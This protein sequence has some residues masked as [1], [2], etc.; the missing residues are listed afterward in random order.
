[1]KIILKCLAVIVI[2]TLCSFGSIHLYE[3]CPKRKEELAKTI[4]NEINNYVENKSNIILEKMAKDEGF[5]NTVKTLSSIGDENLREVIIS[6][7]N[8]NPQTLEDFIRDNASFIASEIIET[9]EF[10]AVAKNIDNEET[11]NVEE[12]NVST[13]NPNQKYIDNWEKLSNSDVAPYIGPK[14][15]KI[16]VVEFF[17]F[18]C[19]HCKA[20]APIVSAVAKNNPDVKFVFNPLYFM[21]DHSPY[22]AKV[23]MAAH[24]KGKFIEVYDGI[25]TLPN[26][27]EETIN[28]ILVDEGLDIEE[29]KKMI[30]EKDIRRGSQD[31]D[32]LS[33]VLGING[34]PMFIVNG[35]PFYGR[36]IEEFQNKINSLR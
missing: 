28:Q 13:E 20:T 12:Q 31:I 1:M 2:A 23:A 11:Q 16:R 9:E 32:A 19:G 6:Y 24:K 29:I 25:M 33:Q 3:N 15:A 30:E 35:E 10:K 18:N 21:S 4:N 26:M 27:N 8:N 22:A 14:D 5:R 7:F 17:D 34:V 36:S